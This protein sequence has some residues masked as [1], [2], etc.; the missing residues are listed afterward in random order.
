MQM[1]PKM[2]EQGRREGVS[3]VPS[4]RGMLN[5]EWQ[6]VQS[7][8][9]CGFGCDRGSRGVMLELRGSGESGDVFSEGGR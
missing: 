2:W 1:D 9:K 7:V 8:G 6:I 4:G 3:V 5:G